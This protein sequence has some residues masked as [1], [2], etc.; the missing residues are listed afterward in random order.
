MAP[1]PPEDDVRYTLSNSWNL[2]KASARILRDDRSLLVFPLL[3]AVAFVGLLATFVAPTFL[4]GGPAALF[5]EARPVGYVLAFLF[6]MAQY[7]VAFYFNA[8]LVGAA[9]IHLD[10]GRPTLAD[11]LRIASDH[12]APILGYAAISATVGLL[13]NAA[14]RRGKLGAG[15]VSGLLGAAWNLATF[16]AVPVLV[17]RNVGPIDALR[18]SARLLRQTWGEQVSGMVGMGLA[19]GLLGAVLGVLSVG[20]IVVAAGLGPFGYVPV[21]AALLV[22]WVLF[23]LATSAIQGIYRAAVYRYALTGQAGVGFE[24]VRLEDLARG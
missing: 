13:L 18:E 10:G 22:F 23:A 1:L 12:A 21:I 11:G 8:A 19:F 24:E 2:V 17:T 6:Y 5:G 3:S 20:L 9:L 4:V 16:L 15:L 14:S 7:F